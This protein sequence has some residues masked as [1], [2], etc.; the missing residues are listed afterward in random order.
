MI[1]MIIKLLQIFPTKYL[2]KVHRPNTMKQNVIK[3]PNCAPRPDTQ[4]SLHD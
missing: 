2:T 4:P 1:N 3:P